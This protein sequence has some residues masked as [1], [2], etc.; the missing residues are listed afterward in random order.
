[1]LFEKV[2][3]QWQLLYILFWESSDLEWYKDKLTEY[4]FCFWVNY[5]NLVLLFICNSYVKFRG[6]EMYLETYN[7]DIDSLL[8]VTS[9]TYLQLWKY[10]YYY[11]FFNKFFILYPSDPITLSQA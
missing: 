6:T 5:P 3:P 4:N 2:P 10:N 8:N 1:M 9:I 11:V 7:M